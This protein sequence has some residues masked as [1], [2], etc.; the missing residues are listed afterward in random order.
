MSRD[1]LSREIAEWVI[2]IG[3]RPGSCAK[4]L[5]GAESLATG[6]LAV[7]H[8]IDHDTSLGASRRRIV[9]AIKELT[10]SVPSSST[11]VV[12][13]CEESAYPKRETSSMEFQERLTALREIL[14]STPPTEFRN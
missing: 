10:K 3:E 5:Y 14:A 1:R 7:Q 2:H 12:F 13:L 9:K 6:L 11:Q 8:S 4:D